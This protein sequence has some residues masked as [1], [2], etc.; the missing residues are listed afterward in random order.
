[1]NISSPQYG[2]DE[3]CMAYQN[4]L[5]GDLLRLH[6]VCCEQARRVGQKKL[7][8]GDAKNKKPQ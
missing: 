3:C 8:N 5:D 2:G 6:S 7:E 4:F 1:M